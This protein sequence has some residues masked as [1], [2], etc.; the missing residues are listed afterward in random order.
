MKIKQS[1]SQYPYEWLSAILLFVY[2]FPAVFMMDQAKH[3]I[4]DN[5]DGMMPLLKFT[6][7][8]NTYFAPWNTEIPGIMNGVPRA[9]LAPWSF[10]SFLFLF[11]KPLTAYSIHYIFQHTVA[12][13]GMR[14]LIRDFVSN[15][16]EIYNG[17]A[18][19]FAFLPFW[20]GGELAV[21]GLPILVWS[22]LKFTF[23]KPTILH[24]IVFLLFPFYSSLAIGN[25][26]SFP[27][28]L[29]T[30]YS[31]F[32]LIEKKKFDFK[33]LLPPLILFI[34]TFVSEYH[35]LQFL[36]SGIETN[37]LD[38]QPKD[39]ILNWKGVIGVSILSFF[40]G[41]YHFQSLH[42][43]ILVTVISFI[44]IGFY[45][46]KLAFF[47][48]LNSAFM[49][50][51]LIL[52]FASVLTT[53]YN[54]TKL[55]EGLPRINFR[56]WVLWPML[57]YL[58]FAWVLNQLNNYR[59]RQF[60]ILIQVLWVGLLLYPNDY[61]GSTDAEN[62]FAQT[63]VKNNIGQYKTFNEY[64]E[65]E[66]FTELKT[67][68]PEICKHNTVSL[69]FNP[70]ITLYNE[71]PVYDAYLN[72]YPL[73]KWESWKTINKEEH[74]KGANIVFSSNKA[75]LFSFELSKGLKKINKPNWNYEEFKK[76]GVSYLITNKIEIDVLELIHE[77][78]K[79]NV[80]K[81]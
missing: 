37:R 13:I 68:Y 41:H 24:Y 47:N 51:L 38:F 46:Y 63:I 5:L 78:D 20:P 60:L 64:F 43:L 16:A 59:G 73:S 67:F 34:G 80:Y 10:F 77:T 74:K 61:F 12:F 18:L 21:A 14:V 79:F 28:I 42:I 15:K 31:W 72:I 4:H 71:I 7:N 33:L 32:F 65:P 58:L 29:L 81:L 49:G 56:L 6:G 8:W 50:L 36:F 54:N 69:G 66:A 57:W 23:H 76:N 44:I 1:I 9:S 19:A 45:N 35:L 2:L 70:A 62:I 53:L 40:F 11:F 48:K 52:I 30:V 22:L 25:L 39:G 55:F 17:V 75:H 27:L 26:F 3:L